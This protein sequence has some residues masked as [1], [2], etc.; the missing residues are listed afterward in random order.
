[1]TLNELK[2]KYPNDY[3]LGEQF[4]AGFEF[5]DDVNEYEAVRIL[6]EYPNS[7]DL[8]NYLRH[9]FINQKPLYS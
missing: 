9:E 3:D 2:K 5:I 1:M 7:Y 4:S 6:K 8:G